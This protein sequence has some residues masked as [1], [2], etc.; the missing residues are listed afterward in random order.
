MIIVNIEDRVQIPLT[1]IFI[2]GNSVF[3]IEYRLNETDRTLYGEWSP[4]GMLILNTNTT[5][6]EIENLVVL[7]LGN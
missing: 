4:G 3:T 1:G 2:T 7:R 6:I 5:S